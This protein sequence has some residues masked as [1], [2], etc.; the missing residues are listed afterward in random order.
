MKLT[1]LGRRDCHLC[2]EAAAMLFDLRE[3]FGL[4]VNPVDIDQ[5]DE[6]VKTYGLRIPVILDERG[7]VLAEGLVDFGLLQAALADADPPPGGSV[8]P[9]HDLA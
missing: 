4:E 9:E 1:L 6:L 5:D 7:R 2:E 8:E 3:R